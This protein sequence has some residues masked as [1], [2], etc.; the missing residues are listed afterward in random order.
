MVDQTATGRGRQGA[1]GPAD[2]AVRAADLVTVV[3]ITRDRPREAAATVA[4]LR[5]LP[6]APTV[7]V[8]VNGGPVPDV[9]DVPGCRLVVLDRNQAAAGR[10]VGVGCS[11][12]PFVA[13]S[14][15]DSWWA[16][17][18]LERAAALLQAEPSLGLVH[19]LVRVE[20]A[21]R[22]DPFC[23]ELRRSPLTRGPGPGTPVLGFMACA[24]VVRR[25]AY[26]A[27]GGFGRGATT[28]V[29]G[30]EDRLAIDLASAGWDL[31][32][33]PEVVA[34]HAPS[35]SR[36]PDGRRRTELRSRLLTAWTRLPFALAVR[37]S[38]RH[39]R[40]A[41]PK[42]SI[43]VARDVLRSWRRIRTA[44]QVAPPD[45]VREVRELLVASRT[46]AAPPP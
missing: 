31:R 20:P 14:D 7:V 25:D 16:P 43:D 22:D 6:E 18:A 35:P 1:A 40:Q 17:G 3:M 5:R 41:P 11:T 24:A 29:G 32:Y 36:D 9:A 13:F 28:A 4:R 26:L 2:G 39:L 23:E 15:D 12:T 27:A 37:V 42:V 21:G 45:V 10:D 33:V 19:A 30:E 34:H 44:R 8:V 38:L 46:P